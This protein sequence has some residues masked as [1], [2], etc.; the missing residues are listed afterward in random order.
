MNRNYFDL[1]TPEG[2]PTASFADEMTAK[3]FAVAM[4]DPLGIGESSVPADPY[5]L[6]PE[7]QARALAAA[8]A[9]LVQRC[10]ERRYFRPAGAARHSHRWRR[11]LLRCRAQRRHSGAAADL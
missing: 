11:A 7:V 8:V 5:E 3:G 2:E 10:A 9:A 6:T 4:L 1:P